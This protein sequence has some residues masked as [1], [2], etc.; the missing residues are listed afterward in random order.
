MGSPP[1][2]ACLTLFQIESEAIGNW[3]PII[4]RLSKMEHKS[5][6][7]LKINPNGKLPAFQAVDTVR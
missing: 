7:M 5:P 1:S 4:V 2:R 3:E 6:E